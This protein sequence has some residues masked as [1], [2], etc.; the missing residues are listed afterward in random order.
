MNFHIINIKFF[1]Q[2]VVFI[3]SISPLYAQWSTTETEVI[4]SL[5]LKYGGQFYSTGTS[6]SIIQFAE[7][8]H[9]GS[10]GILFN[11]YKAFPEASGSLGAIGNTKYAKSAGSNN[12]GAGSIMFYGNSGVMS[13]YV[14]PVSTGQDSL[15]D[16]GMPYLWI[17]RNRGVAINNNYIPTGYKLAVAGKII[18]EEITIQLNSSWPDYVFNKN[19]QLK[20]LDEV[21]KFISVN[22]HLPGIPNA[23]SVEENGV[24][25]GEISSLLLQKIEEL[26]LYTLAQQKAINELKEELE[27]L[28]QD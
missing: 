2:G 24:D 14:S 26:T 21:E 10:H 23:K 8:I 19:Y 3:T 5:N 1:L 27:K 28:K 6:N 12:R 15:V 20:S 17:Q 13:F 16:W 9:S 11:A 25:L 7:K 18:A 4:T 22:G